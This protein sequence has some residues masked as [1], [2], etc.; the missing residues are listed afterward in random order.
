MNNV[1][2]IVTNLDMLMFSDEAAKDECTPV[3]RRGWS[4]Q[5]S[6]CVQK[7]CFIRGHYFSILPILTLDGIVA[8]DIIKGSVTSEKFIQ[9]LRELVVSFHLQ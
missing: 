4:E 5:G 2:D 7:K 3:R 1:T 6:R 9:F 8:Y